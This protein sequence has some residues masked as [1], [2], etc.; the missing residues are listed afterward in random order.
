MSLPPARPGKGPGR[1]AP[2]LLLLALSILAPPGSARQSATKISPAEFR[3]RLNARLTRGGMDRCIAGVMVV[4]L[5]DSS[6]LAERNSSVLLHPGSNMKLLTTGAALAVLPPDF[7][8]RTTVWSD[9]VID[10]GVLSGNLYV[11]GGGDPLLDSTAVD[12]IAG[13]AAAAGIRRVE[14]DLVADLSL[15]DTL[16]W[17]RGWMWDDEPDPDEGFISPLSFNGSSA[18]VVV[19]PG[20]RAGDGVS[21]TVFPDPGFFEI[22][23]DASTVPR[24]AADSLVVTRMRGFDRIVVGGTLAAG[25]Q[26]ETTVVSVRRPALHFLHALRER[27]IARGI[28]VGGGLLAGRASGPERLGTIEHGLRAVVTRI[29][30]LSD[31][32]AAESLLKTL[33][34][35]LSGEPGTAELGLDAVKG[36]LASAGI[37]PASV[38]LADGSGVSWYDAVTPADIVAVLRDQYSRA[39]TF[40][41]FF[42]S[43][44]RAGDDGTLASRMAGTAAEDRV[45]AKTGTLTGVSALS[46]YATT[47]THDLIAFSIVL[48]HFPGKPRELRALQDSVL[49]DLVLLGPGK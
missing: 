47:L 11:V 48:N 13:M 12:S 3:T 29:N 44:P 20:A 9:P 40:P 5:A 43:L 27:L 35:R 34:A 14:G 41:S 1:A 24:G 15:F 17:G 42:A 36:Y 38:I 32:L 4:R 22:G 7:T 31:N 37:D 18:A 23:N 25:A 21:C 10:D 46:G 2:A 39:S 6:V 19:S 28:P 33:A 16:S 30:K 45:S 8:F 49:N 26:P